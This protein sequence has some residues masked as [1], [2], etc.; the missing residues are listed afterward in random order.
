[1]NTTPTGTTPTSNELSQSRT[2]LAD[3]RSHL[4]NER[5]HLAYLRTCVSLIGFGITLNR[6]SEFLVQNDAMKVGAAGPML[7]DTGNVGTGMVILGIA[8]AVWSLYRYKRVNHD[9]KAASFRP[10]DRAITTLTLLFLLIGGITAVW[11]FRA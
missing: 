8:L 1:M 4:A 5:T 7:R 6:F 3:L 10:M 2:G 9:I 11:L